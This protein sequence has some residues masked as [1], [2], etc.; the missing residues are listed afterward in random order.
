MSEGSESIFSETS[1]INPIKEAD[2][3]FDLSYLIRSQKSDESQAQIVK[4]LLEQH[5]EG[6]TLANAKDQYGRTPLCIAAQ[7]GEIHIAHMLVANFSAD[8]NAKDYAPKPCS[9]LDHAVANNKQAFV[10]FLLDADVD[11]KNLLEQN[12]TRFLEMKTAIE[13]RRKRASQQKGKSKKT[14]RTS[15]SVGA[16][17]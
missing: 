17:T 6:S 3:P 5:P 7:F 2:Q 1:R 9:V 8:V 16:L 13:F 12:R 4:H 10:G 11:Q 15:S 14:K